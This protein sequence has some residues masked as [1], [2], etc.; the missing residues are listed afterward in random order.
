MESF[1]RSGWVASTGSEGRGLNVVKGYARGRETALQDGK[2]NVVLKG[3][4]A[5]AGV[6][7]PQSGGRF[8]SGAYSRYP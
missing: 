3:K 4:D 5:Q 2:G 7:A 6:P 1:P 8:A